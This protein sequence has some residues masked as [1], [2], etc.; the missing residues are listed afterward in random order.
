MTTSSKISKRIFDILFSSIGLIL[1]SPILL[2]ISIIIKITSEGP[3]LFKQVRVA[4]DNKDFKI[5]K[6]R[7]MIVD[8]DKKGLKITVKDDPRITKIG[9]FLRK[10]KLDELPQLFNVLLGDMSF[11]GPRPEVRK[12]VDL[13]TEEQK[14]VLSVRPGIT[15]LAS[16][17]YR[18]ENELLDQSTNPEDTYINEIMPSKLKINLDYVKNINLVNDIKLILLTIKTVIKD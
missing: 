3:I 18:N 5:L 6:F 4:K 8:A 14:Q 2:V 17:K 10:T 9:K 7:T 16:I 15:D 1:I 12:Y 11:V 13:Y